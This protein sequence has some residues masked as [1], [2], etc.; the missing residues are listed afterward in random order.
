MEYKPLKD[1]RGRFMPKAP[2]CRLSKPEVKTKRVENV[3]TL[4]AMNLMKQFQ[5]RSLKQKITNEKKV[6]KPDIA[7]GPGAA[8]TKPFPSWS[9]ADAARPREKEYIEPWVGEP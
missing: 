5:E 2:L 6:Q 3:D 7:F 8:A 4:H 1:A 9:N